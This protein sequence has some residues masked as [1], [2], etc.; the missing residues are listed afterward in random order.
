MIESLTVVKI[1]GGLL[2][3]GSA[4]AAHDD[5][6]ERVLRAIGRTAQARHMVILAGGGPFAD[7]VRAFDAR[8]AISASAAH[9]MALASMDVYAL[10]I[11]DRLAGAA[12]VES[13]PAVHAALAAGRIPVLAASRWLRAADVLP[14]SWDAT[15]DSAAAFVAGALDAA[16]LVFVKPVAGPVAALVDR[17]ALSL[18]PRGLP[19]AVAAVDEID[20]LDGIIAGALAARQPR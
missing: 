13:A 17:Y 5:A 2:A 12:V 1:G 11:A 19:M 18:A 15:S 9:W 14:H 4:D 8:H 10:A 20:R 3:T 7:A 16:A 6:L